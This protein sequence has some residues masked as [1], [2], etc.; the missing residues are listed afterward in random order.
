MIWEFIAAIS[1]IVVL[2]IGKKRKVSYIPEFIAGSL[3]GL[4]WELST[5]TLF[6]YGSSFSI[7]LWKDVP[8]GMIFLWGVSVAGFSL[9]SDYLQEKIPV[10]KK[11]KNRELKNNLFWD[12]MVA[13]LI[14]WSLEI[15]GSQIFKMWSYPSG[16]YLAVFNTPVKWL[17]GWSLVGIMLLGVVRRYKSIL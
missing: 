11:G 14:G 1:F 2:L 9:I 15:A 10:A 13:S 16:Q 3:Y 6:N 12:I 17:L 4:W 7:Y 8:L 5:E